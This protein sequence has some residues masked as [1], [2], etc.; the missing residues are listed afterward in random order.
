MFLVDT[1]SLLLMYLSSAPLCQVCWFYGSQLKISE[2]APL[3]GHS[4]Q[5]NPDSKLVWPH[6]SVL[7]LCSYLLGSDVNPRWPE[8]LV[9]LSFVSPALSGSPG[10]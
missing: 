2:D 4:D 9:S 8:A 7:R 10:T 1:G 6:E 5:L 3:G